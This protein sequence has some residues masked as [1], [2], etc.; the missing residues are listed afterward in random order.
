LLLLRRRRRR[1]WQLLLKVKQGLPLPLLK[2][3]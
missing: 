1:W 3:S 2:E